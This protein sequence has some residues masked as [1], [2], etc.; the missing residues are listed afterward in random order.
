MPDFNLTKTAQ[1][2]DDTINLIDEV[3]PKVDD[4]FVASPGVPLNQTVNE[5]SSLH[6]NGFD[7][8][9][10]G[11]WAPSVGGATTAGDYDIVVSGA[12]YTRI[13]NMVFARCDI[14]ISVVTS[15][16]SGTAVVGNL[17]FNYTSNSNIRGCVTTSGVDLPA[18]IIG[19]ST[20]S[21]VSGVGNDLIFLG[22]VDNS[23]FQLLQISGF[24]AG[25]KITFSISYEAA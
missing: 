2:V 14:T 24:S 1:S 22:T 5:F 20:A 9:E 15:V 21:L 11:S 18:G 4:S 17:P 10:E 12:R 6:N 19:L 23:P 8:Y 25:D 3:T 16:G 13:G 7:T